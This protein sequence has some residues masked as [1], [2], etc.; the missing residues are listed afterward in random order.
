MWRKEGGVFQQR[1]VKLGGGDYYEPLEGLAVGERVVISR[2]MLI[3]GQAQ[4]NDW[5]IPSV[6]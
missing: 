1:K 6:Q 4:I 3:A 5:A 2:Q